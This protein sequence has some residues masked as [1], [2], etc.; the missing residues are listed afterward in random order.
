MGG[1]EWDRWNK[2]MREQVPTQQVKN[3]KEQGSWDPG[4]D[5]TWGPMAGRLYTTCLSIYLLEVYYRHLP[6]YQ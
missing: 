5:G 2:V 6:L 3:G 1:S 4:H